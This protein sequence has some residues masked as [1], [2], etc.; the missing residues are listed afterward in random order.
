VERQVDPPAIPKADIFP[1][2]DVPQVAERPLDSF[3]DTHAPGNAQT[4]K[5]VREQ[6]KLAGSPENTAMNFAKNIN[7]HRGE[8]VSGGKPGRAV[9]SL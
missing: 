3:A 4:E 9:W 7:P 8:F 6:S 1:E 2:M 5:A